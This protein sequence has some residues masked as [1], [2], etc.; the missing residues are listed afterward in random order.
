MIWLEDFDEK[1]I[2]ISTG[3]CAANDNF[4]L[5]FFFLNLLTIK[6][7]N[8]IF[9]SL[10][11]QSFRGLHCLARRYCGSYCQVG[12]EKTPQ[13]SVF[14]SLSFNMVAYHINMLKL[15]AEPAAE[16][17]PESTMG[18]LFQ[19]YNP[20]YKQHRLGREIE[21]LLLLG[22]SQQMCYYSGKLFGG[23]L[24]FLM[25]R[26]LADC[27]EEPAF[28]ASLNT[29]FKRSVPPTA[30]IMLRAW[31]EKLEGR[32]IYLAGLIQ[33]PGESGEWVDAITA[34]ALFIKPRL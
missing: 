4:Q 23:Y 27:C 24:T 6:M 9:P 16:R 12:L 30:P 34:E 15:Q 10:L 26:V 29:S 5:F 17:L 2:S 21:S 32:K 7:K 22:P 1:V 19:G 8:N 33:I 18:Y 11:L 25:D 31:P 3:V 20:I 28:T 14:V 13:K